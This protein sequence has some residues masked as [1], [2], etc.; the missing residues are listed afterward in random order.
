M[1]RL[2]HRLP[3]ELGK[4]DM[5]RARSIVAHLK[6]ALRAERRKGRAGHWS[7]DLNRH[8][9]LK[10]ALDVESGDLA[11]LSQARSLTSKTPA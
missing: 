1:P 6:C 11:R 9:A 4:D 7:Y 3:Q 5:E 10:T 2:I 8:I